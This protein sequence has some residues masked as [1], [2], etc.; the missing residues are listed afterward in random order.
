MVRSQLEPER[1]DP[2]MK[3]TG[4][5]GSYTVETSLP[6]RRVLRRTAP[7]FANIAPGRPENV[8]FLSSTPFAESVLSAL[9]LVR[10]AAF[11]R[12]PSYRGADTRGFEREW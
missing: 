12:M 9:I 1:C 2:T 8:F 10:V 5:R 6:S 3:K 11:L 4:E 7:F